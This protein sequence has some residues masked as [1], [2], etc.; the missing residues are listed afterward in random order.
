MDAF[1][2]FTHPP[3]LTAP[4]LPSVHRDPSPPSSLPRCSRRTFPALHL[5]LTVYFA[6]DVCEVSGQREAVKY[7]LIARGWRGEH[8]DRCF[9]GDSIIDGCELTQ[10]LGKRPDLYFIGGA[11]SQAQ[12]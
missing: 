12:R 3:T 1:L 10:G 4:H 7:G 2:L 8:F 6:Q 5:S 11:F 9:M